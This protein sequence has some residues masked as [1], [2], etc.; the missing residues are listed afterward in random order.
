MIVT[1]FEEIEGSSGMT[2]SDSEGF[3]Q[4]LKIS[5]HDALEPLKPK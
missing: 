4:R 2:V 3:G 1:A 5:A